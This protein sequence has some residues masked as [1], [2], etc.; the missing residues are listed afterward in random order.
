MKE[1]IYL[2]GP[3]MDNINKW[4]EGVIEYIKRK[5]LDWIHVNVGNEGVGKT[6]LSL[7]VCE[8]ID[9][10]FSINNVVFTI[11]ELIEQIKDSY[12][13]K[14][15][16]IDEGALLFFT[17]DAMSNDTKRAVKLLTAMRTYNLFV[18]I[19]VPNYWV[20]D[21]YIREHRVKSVTQVPIRGRYRYYCPS[22][23]KDLRQDKKKKY[24]TIWPSYDLN[25]YFNKCKGPLWADYIKKKKQLVIESQSV[26]K[27][28][29]EQCP[30]CGYP[31]LCKAKTLMRTCPNCNHKWAS[32]TKK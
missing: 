29:N 17:R 4:G 23:V 31:W 8:A 7:D 14:C 5:D 26:L 24:K 3:S 15:I 25:G 22:K 10:K 30:K 32:G 19:N 6:T 21:K 2:T 9:P 28:T 16:I 12:P 1:G 11:D 20:L 18:W 27:S 13:G